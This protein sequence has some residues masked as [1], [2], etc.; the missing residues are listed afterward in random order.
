MS[1]LYQSAYK[2]QHSTETALLC[3]CEDIKRA[4]DIKNGTALIMLDLSAAFDTIDHTIILH[5]LRHRYGISGSALKWIESYLTNRCQHVCLNDV[6][7]HR[8]MLSTWVPHG[9]VLGPLL[10]S[11][12]I[13]LIG[14]I[15]RKHGLRFHHYADD[16]QIYANF[17]YN[18]QSIDVCLERLCMCHGHSGVVENKQ[19]CYE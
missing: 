2:P 3:V 10:F 5:R 7:S 18:S 12:Y 1:A 17:E 8:F 14:D 15:V 19:T 6:Y 11:L 4:F 16:L 13:L 9:S